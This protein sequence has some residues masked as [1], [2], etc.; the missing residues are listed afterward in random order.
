MRSLD[1]RYSVDGGANW[2]E[3]RIVDLG[4]VGNFIHPVTERRFG[5]GTEWIF[6]FR[7]TDNFKC[8]ILS[9]SWQAEVS[10]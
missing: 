7:M 6:D 3:W 2:S 5:R 4:N 10:Q 8:D 1:I 9:A